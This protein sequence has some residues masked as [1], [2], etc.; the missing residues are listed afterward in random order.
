M[1]ETAPAHLPEAEGPEAEGPEAEGPE[2]VGPEAVVVELLAF[3]PDLP[4][5]AR[6]RAGDAAAD[7]PA[8]HDVTLGPGER[9]LVATGFAIALPADHCGLV[10]SR[11]GLVL[12][13]GV[14]VLNAPGLIDSGYR[15]ELKVVLYN[16]SRKE[17]RI[18]RGQRV[19]QLLVL[20]VPP[21]VLRPV[22]ELPPSP[23]D[24]GR[25]GFGSS[26]R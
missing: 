25:A 14:C 5:P 17:V 18:E 10:L 19:A 24:R 16:T 9:A 1:H 15:G 11:S 13:H 26:G 6:I 22:D 21:L 3:D 8:R 23:D 20:P 4:P 2:A 7:L 12:H